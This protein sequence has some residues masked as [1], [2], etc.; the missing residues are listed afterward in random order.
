MRKYKRHLD[1]MLDGRKRVTEGI[2]KEIAGV[3]Q[4]RDGIDCFSV[5]INVGEKDDPRGRPAVLS[6]RL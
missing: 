1:Y 5:L 2:L 6:G 4:D 3:M